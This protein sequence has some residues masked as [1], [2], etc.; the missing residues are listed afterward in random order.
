MSESS[1]AQ[2]PLR[3]MVVEDNPIIRDLF[4]LAI[5]RLQQELDAGE[6]SVAMREAGDGATAWD[7]LQ[8]QPADLLV[9][10]L[11][12]PILGGLEII[13]RVREDPSLQSTRILAISASIQDARDR[14]LGA[15]A[16]RF[17]QKPL[18][19]VEVLDAVRTLLRLPMP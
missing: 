12:L 11:Y 10:D 13:R 5:E 17:L 9:V 3:I 8:E 16:D 14:S 2:Q 19:L 18:R 15:G 7:R 6:H 4:S 1:S